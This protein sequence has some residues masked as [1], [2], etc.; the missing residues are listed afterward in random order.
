MYSSIDNGSPCPIPFRT[1]IVS[2]LKLLKWS[3]VLLLDGSNLT[4][5]TNEVSTFLFLRLWTSLSGNAFEK[6]PSMS[7]NSVDTT[8][9]DLHAE[10]ILCI[11]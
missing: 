2:D 7:R 10:W 5:F 8:L 11:K 6:V 9:L 4:N 3:L 1:W